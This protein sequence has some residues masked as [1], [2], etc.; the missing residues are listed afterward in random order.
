M[1]I[2]YL[3]KI[4]DEW[5]KSLYIPCIIQPYEYSSDKIIDLESTTQLQDIEIY[6]IS[7]NKIKSILYLQ[8]Q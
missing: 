7:K 4:K 8:P 2:K 6:D 3:Q 5:I 1:P